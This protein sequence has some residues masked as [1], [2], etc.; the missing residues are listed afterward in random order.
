LGQGDGRYWTWDKERGRLWFLGV[1]RVA[2]GL[3]LAQLSGR[4]VE[5]PIAVVAG[6]IGV[7]KAHLYG[8][9]HSGRRQANPISRQVQQQLTGLAERTQRHYG[10]VARVKRQQNIAIGGKY[11]QEAA[12]ECAWRRGRAVFEFY[13]SQKRREGA[14]LAWHLP[15]TYRG[16]HQ[17]AGRSRQR[18]INRTL[19]DLVANVAQGNSS[20]VVERRYVNNG[21]AAVETQQ[22]NRYLTIYW[23][24]RGEA[25]R[26]CLW[27]LLPAVA[28]E[29][30]RK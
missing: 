13:D 3:G 17:Q 10:R 15:S 28:G 8:A 22:H 24:G 27:Y 4:P 23:Q 25:G 30:G 5:L 12:Q 14:Y 9:W 21:R 19:K 1:A 26:A 7:F 2:A 20:K 11:N 16:P 6:D 18:K 29:K